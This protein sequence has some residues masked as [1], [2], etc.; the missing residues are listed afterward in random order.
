MNVLNEL[1]YGVYILGAR[2]GKPGGCVVNTV[3]QVTSDPQTVLVSV[4]HDNRTNEMIK[5]TKKFS[6]SILGEN[7]DPKIIG[8]FGYSSSRDV[9][10]FEDIDYKELSGVPIILDSTS[11]FVCEVIDIMETDSHTVFL[12]RVIETEKLK[13]DKPMTYEYY[14]RV[15]KGKS[16]KN[17]PTY[18]SSIEDKPNKTIWKCELCGYEYEG[19]ELPE[20]F[21][22]PICGATGEFF[23]KK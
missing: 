21:V 13:D 9:D 3:T 19:E 2:D 15:L 8:L 23:S 12:G 11:A 20:D 17:A 18:D 1:S 5:N 22:C 14:H 7:I 4:N 16:P 6:V 10:K